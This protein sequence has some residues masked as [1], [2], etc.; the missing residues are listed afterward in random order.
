[1]SST[2]RVV[3]L[4][5]SGASTPELMDAIADWP[6]GPDRRPV[7]DVVL[8]GRSAEK[9]E[10]V[11]DACRSRLPVAVEGVTVR[12]ET[13]LDQALEGAD[14]VLI[15]VRIGGLDARTFDETFPRAFGLPGEETMGPGGFADALRTVPAM[16]E[17][18]DRLA[19]RASG[20]FVINLTNPSGIVTQAATAHA[21]QRF[22]SVCDGPVT[23]VEG[24]ARA[25][26]RDTDVIRLGYAGLNHCGFW[27]DADAAT[28]VAALP[29]TSGADE[30]DVAA[31]GA[32]PT[33]Y[34]RF[35]LHPD[36]QLSAQLASGESR[37]QA[38]KRM[39]AQM[40]D[41]YASGVAAG[42][43]T[44]RG[45]LWYRVSIV[46]LIDAVIHGG[47]DTV[48]LG[49][50]NEGAVSWAPDDAIVELPTDIRAG[51]ALMRRPSVELPDPV[52]DLLKQHATFEAAT[53]RAL[54]GCRS[55]QNLAI[56]REA[57]VEA[58]AANPMVPT[59]A[60]AARLVDHILASSPA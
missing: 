8:Q 41:Q 29:A 3:V 40:L 46:P 60:L 35:Y 38:L 51:G 7:L 32:L 58:L 48:I 45:A 28:L 37:A 30:S 19:E 27:M 22:V 34:V 57:L 43:Q 52:A 59:E 4:G 14:V 16:A 54:A 55:R 20:A 24:I 26:G 36:R 44:R 13:S 11:A 6:G 1:M 18:W 15:Q 53:A 9:L 21:G 10:L 2:V 5:G 12:T 56:R 47:E 33:P 17:T 50:P 49:L 31:L 25:T 23:F 42:E 39:E